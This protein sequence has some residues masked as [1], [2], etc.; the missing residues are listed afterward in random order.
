[1]VDG[2]CQFDL[3]F[4]RILKMEGVDIFKQARLFSVAEFNR[5]GGLT[6]DCRVES[7]GHAHTC[8]KVY[9]GIVQESTPLLPCVPC[10]A[11]AVPGGSM[12]SCSAP[13][14]CYVC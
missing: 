1:M 6:V 8:G 10:C 3:V 7:Q 2:G 13:I 11:L 4:Q 12:R 14:S 9:R 5:L